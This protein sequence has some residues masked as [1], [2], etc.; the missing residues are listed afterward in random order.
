[1]LPAASPKGRGN[2]YLAVPS[3]YE[4]SAGGQTHAGAI[5]KDVLPNANGGI[6]GGSLL[7]DIHSLPHAF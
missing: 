1:M 6:S 2:L 4:A 7:G 5:W 3:Q